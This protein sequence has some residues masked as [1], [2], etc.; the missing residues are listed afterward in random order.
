MFWKTENKEVALM[1]AVDVDD[2]LVSGN[3]TVELR[4]VSPV[5]EI[6]GTEAMG[7]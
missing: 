1:L 6:L 2:I 7:Q 5:G 3:Q 4:R